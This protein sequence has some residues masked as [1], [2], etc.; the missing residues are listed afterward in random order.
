MRCVFCFQTLRYI[1][2]N[3]SCICICFFLLCKEIKKWIEKPNLQK[4]QTLRT[5]DYI[6]VPHI[7]SVLLAYFISDR[8]IF[9]PFYFPT[10]YVPYL[11]TLFHSVPP[12]LSFTIFIFEMIW[13]YA[14]MIAFPHLIQAASLSLALIL[15]I[16]FAFLERHT[17][18]PRL[19]LWCHIRTD[20]K[21]LTNK[22]TQNFNVTPCICLGREINESEGSRRHKN[23]ETISLFD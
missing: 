22:P 17:S 18:C 1:F 13:H 16:P 19:F 9:F 2:N 11:F 10:F 6:Q 8:F 12:S 23:D 21:I 3:I 7:Y 5:Y 14:K 20:C 15:P 4:T